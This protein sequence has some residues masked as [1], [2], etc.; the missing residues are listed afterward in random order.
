M[1]RYDEMPSIVATMIR[2][3]VIVVV[4]VELRMDCDLNV[5]RQVRK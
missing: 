2:M 1:V 4:V 3:T 5:P